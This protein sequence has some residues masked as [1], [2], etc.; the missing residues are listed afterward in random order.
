MSYLP[1]PLSFET[2]DA[3]KGFIATGSEVWSPRPRTVVDD[4]EGR[5][6]CHG[7]VTLSE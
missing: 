5:L 6:A 3:A 2:V 1:E 4:Q 7:L